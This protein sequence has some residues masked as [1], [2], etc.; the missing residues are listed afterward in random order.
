MQRRKWGYWL[1]VCASWLL[2]PLSAQASYI[3]TTMGTAVVNDATAAYFNPA[4]LTLLKGAQIIPLGT[5]ARYQTQFSGSTMAV[6]T[7]FKSVGSSNSTSYY[8][9][10]SLYAGMP[11]NSRIVVGFAAVTNFASRNPEDSSILRYIQSSNTIQDYD[12][13]PAIGVK[14]NDVFALGAGVNFSYTNFHLQPIVGFPGSNIA[15]SQ[16]NNRTDGSGIG[17]NAGFL[18][19]PAT[20][21]L[22]GFDYRTLTTYRQSG[23]SSISGPSSITSNRYHYELRTPG[24][25]TMSVNHWITPLFAVIGTIQR[26]QWGVIKNMQVY[27]VAALSGSTAVVTNGSIPYHLRDTWVLTLGGNYKF[28]PNWVAR[29]AATYN[30][31]P[32]NGHYQISTGDSYIL[33]LSL[34]YDINPSIKLDGGYAHAFIQDQNIN[35]N[36]ARFL[37]NGKNTASRDVVSL[38]LT[39]TMGSNL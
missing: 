26:I 30:Q 8:Y 34:G 28:K 16:G 31:S 11:I 19:R 9:S 13:V 29:V 6:P 36:G 17:A 33:G 21:T 25:G 22:I 12:F 35:I 5:V 27:N 20:N 37:I 2:L 10:P 7:G 14:L 24:R 32:H 23:S 18:F 3:E 4:A 1:Y 15:D 39:M 38:K